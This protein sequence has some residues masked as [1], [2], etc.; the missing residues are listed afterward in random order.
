MGETVNE[1]LTSSAARSEGCSGCFA[2]VYEFSITTTES[3]L[4]TLNSEEFDAYLRV[5]DAN[6]SAVVTDDDGGNG[7]NSRIRQ[8]FGPGTYR[9]EATSFDTGESGAYEFTVRL[10][11]NPVAGVIQVGQT[12]NGNLSGTSGRSVGCDACFADLWQFDVSSTQ[13]LVIALASTE[14]DSYLRVLDSNQVT[15]SSD[16]DGGDGTDSRLVRSFTPGTYFAEAS[17]YDAGESGAYALSVGA[18]AAPVAQPISVGQTASGNL[19]SSAGRSVGCGGCFADLYQFTL[20]SGQTLEIAMNSTAMD[21][22]LRVLNSDFEAVI[23][24]DDSG[25]GTNSRIAHSFAPGTYILEASTFDAGEAG[26]YT[27][28]LLAVAAGPSL[29]PINVGAEASGDITSLS[30]RSTTCTDCFANLHE[31]TVSS[32]QTLVIELSSAAFDAYLRVLDSNGTIVASDDD[33]AGNL[34]S[35]VIHTFAA[36]TYRIEVSTFDAG[37]SGPYS[38]TVGTAAP[39]VVA[40]INIGQTVNANLTA[41][42][43]RS[44]GCG[45][46]YADLYEFSVSSAQMLLLTMTSTEFDT[47]LRVLGSDGVVV[48]F[49][50]DSAGGTNSRIAHSFPAGTYRIEATSYGSAESG[51][52]TLALQSFVEGTLADAPII[53]SLSPSSASAGGDGFVLTV[54]G[55]GFV[56]GSV[57]RW[58]ENDRPTTLVSATE[59]R[60]TISAG[61]L[62][63]AGTAA[64]SVFTPSPGG[65]VSNSLRFSVVPSATLSITPEFLSFRATENGGAPPNQT[66]AI[67]NLGSGSLQWTAAVSTGSGNWLR[68]SRASGS[69]PDFLEV[70]VSPAGLKA[71]VYTGRVTV[72]AG[73]AAPV[74]AVVTLLRHALHSDSSCQPGRLR[75]PGRRRK[76]PAGAEL[77]GFER[78]ARK[79]ELAGSSDHTGRARLVHR[80]TRKRHRARGS[81]RR[82]LDCNGARGR[83]PIAGRRLQGLADAG[84]TRR[85]EFA[86]GNLRDRK[87]PP[88]EQRPRGRRP[89]G[90][91]DFHRGSGRFRTGCARSIPLQHRR[92]VSLLFRRNDCGRKLADRDAERRG[93]E[94]HGRVHPDPGAAAERPGS[95]C[96]SGPAADYV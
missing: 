7:T 69:T 33:S 12:V 84:S 40:A 42:T 52:Y 75:V 9:V 68:L 48:V 93:V 65:G 24:D 4:I 3:L 8:S 43:G 50:D 63:T 88:A 82:E 19:T 70:S 1:T 5:L 87:H 61:D 96:L 53:T 46:C 2:D 36:G 13:T 72:Q 89:A 95:G 59:L 41:S 32:E 58:N 16:D 64:V 51:A 18:T 6:G 92:E 66:M 28:S 11:T 39:S 21:T 67:A 62:S 78:R 81:I 37:E 94:R 31:F 79:H 29:V 47:Y 80:G 34:N 55:R 56:S 35:R 54:A 57:V 85:A 76:E 91:I 90:R 86:A 22:F 23:S 60:A 44:V 14:F 38:L 73:T 25:G 45:G 17:T 26:A 15:L 30:G 10:A 20:A 71:D 83:L 27:V 74:T 49:D 77:P